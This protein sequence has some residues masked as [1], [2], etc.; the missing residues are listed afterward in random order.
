LLVTL[1]G[2]TPQ[3]VASF[4]WILAISFVITGMLLLEIASCE[5]DAAAPG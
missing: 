2:P 1:F 3:M 4:A 5:R